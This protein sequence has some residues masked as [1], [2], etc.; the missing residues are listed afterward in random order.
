VFLKCQQWKSLILHLQQRFGLI[1]K[2]VIFTN[3]FAKVACQEE[4]EEKRKTVNSIF[5]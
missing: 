1:L 5:T 4:R 2:P 3:L